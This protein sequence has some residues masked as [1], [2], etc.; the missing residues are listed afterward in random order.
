MADQRLKSIWMA[1]LTCIPVLVLIY[2]FIRR[3]VTRPLE[4][5]DYGSR[6]YSCRDLE[7][8]EWTFGTYDPL[9]EG[10]KVADA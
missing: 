6:Q 9:G 1:L 2:P 4:D 5:T 8:Y 7:G 3:V 10:G